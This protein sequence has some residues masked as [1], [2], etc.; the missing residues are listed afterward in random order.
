M[1]EVAHPLPLEDVAYLYDDTLEG[2]LS[3]VFLAY[4]RHEVPLDV[5]PSER[6]EPRLGQ[7][8]IAVETDFA[9][10]ERVRRGVVRICGRRAFTA[11][12]RAS[13][14]DDPDT[15]TII[16]RFVRYAMARP[17]NRHSHPILDEL[18]TPEV[19]DLHRLEKH[20]INECEKMRQFVRFSH[21][22]NG[23]WFARVNPNASVVPL[24]MGH[25]TGRFNDQP[26]II[27]DE[28]HEIAGVYD[29]FTWELVRGQAANVPEATARDR[30]IQDAWKRFYD[31][32]SIDAR[33]N[34]ELRRHFMPV[35]FWKNLT[36][37]RPETPAP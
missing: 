9:R 23:I 35:R 10:A 33:Y 2:L 3:A 1:S 21:L 12:M 22:E 26:F 6:F 8:A 28:A 34:P 13:T 25:F 32:L 15:G 24:V 18:T 36:E 17:S 5:V 14:C 7:S 19:V 27:Y 16:Y 20:A 30:Q 37:M 31:V 4:E 11:I 29:G